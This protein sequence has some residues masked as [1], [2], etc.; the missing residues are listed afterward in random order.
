MLS[1][2]MNLEAQSEKE[3]ISIENNSKKQLN[4]RKKDSENKKV[5]IKLE[6]NKHSIENENF[7]PAAL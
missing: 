3:N 1:K 5:I 2:K 7:S 4:K 6:E